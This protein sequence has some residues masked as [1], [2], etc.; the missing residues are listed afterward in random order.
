MNN[1]SREHISKSVLPIRGGATPSE[2]G[3]HPSEAGLHPSEAGLH[4]SEAVS[5]FVPTGE[6][7]AK[8]VPQNTRVN[9]CT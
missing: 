4:P 5:Y 3:L 8:S 6:N 7:S 9:M 1:E 2:V